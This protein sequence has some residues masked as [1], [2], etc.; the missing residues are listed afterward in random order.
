[1]ENLY[2]MCP[3]LLHLDAWDTLANVGEETK[4]HSSRGL[5]R[6]SG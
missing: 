4:H 2:K 5:A 3:V 6:R 1:M